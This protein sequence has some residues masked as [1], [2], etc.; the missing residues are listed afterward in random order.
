M[1]RIYQRPGSKKWWLDFTDV[2]GRRKRMSAETEDKELAQRALEGVEKKIGALRTLGAK[3]GDGPLLLGRY[4]EEIYLPD[5]ESRGK[6]VSN[7][8][9]RLNRILPYVR[10]L[11]VADTR[12]SHIRD[13]VQL[14][15]K[16]M[17]G[18]DPKKRLAPRSILLSYRSLK[19]VFKHAVKAGLL[20]S[21]PCDLDPR[22]D[23]LPKNQDKDLTWRD[24]ARFSQAEIERLLF[25][26]ELPLAHRVV[27][28][29]A[30]AAGPR[31]SE[32]SA[33]RFDDIDYDRQMLPC[34]AISRSYNTDTRM[35]GP[36]KTGATKEVPMHPALAKMLAEWK[37]SGWPALM[38]R[39]P[40]ANDLI[41]P[42]NAKG[43]HLTKW[44]IYRWL[45]RDLV[46]L[47]LRR[48]RSHDFR[49]SFISLVVD[50]DGRHEVIR[51]ATH[52]RKKDGVI[53]GYTSIEWLTL[54]KEVLRL[55]LRRHDGE[56]IQLP[57]TANER[58][59]TAVAQ[60]S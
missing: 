11:A 13:A 17:H 55:R 48:R 52:A 5:R 3:K 29:C 32:I 28:C 33:L 21:N 16:R 18:P 57:T 47:G 7:D 6:D 19:R 38:G 50:N 23:E 60:Q 9:V 46:K 44:D 27:Y 56:L 30:A 10:H 45:Q 24:R 42:R 8:R 1:G 39:M 37:L 40:K 58:N 35:E 41:F 22:D 2:D 51:R 34:I 26:P 54:C 43:E 49:R 14:F 53:E 36:T 4:I 25:S 31:A 59:G 12:L 15:M 20:E